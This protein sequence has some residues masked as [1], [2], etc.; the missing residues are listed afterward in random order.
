ME[1]VS[2]SLTLPLALPRCISL[3]VHCTRSTHSTRQPCSSISRTLTNGKL[4]EKPINEMGNEDWICSVLVLKETI[5]YCLIRRNSHAQ[6]HCFCPGS[7]WGGL[8][9]MPGMR[10]P[11]TST[12]LQHPHTP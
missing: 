4:D 7:T 10:S 6:T 12:W 5:L 2:S 9:G 8:A 11:N 3:D 1:F